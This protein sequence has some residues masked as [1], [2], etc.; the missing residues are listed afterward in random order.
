MAERIAHAAIFRT[1]NCVVFGRD[2]ADC[3]ERS[4]SGTAAK[5]AI[6]GFL[7]GKF[8]FVNR[9]EAASIA[10][11]AGQIDKI[12]P[13]E[14]LISEQ[15]LC[16]GKHIYD[17]ELGYILRRITMKVGTICKLKVN[18]LGNKVGTLGVV[19]WNYS[20]GFQVIFENGG[21]D[22]FSTLRRSAEI[23]EAD[24]FLEEV[25]FE[26]TLLDYQFINVMKVSLDYN[27]GLFD[28]AW[29]EGWK[30]YVAEGWT[31][32][33]ADVRSSVAAPEYEKC[34]VYADYTDGLKPPLLKFKRTDLR[35][36]DATVCMLSDAKDFVDFSHFEYAEFGKSIYP[37]W[38]QKD[39]TICP[40]YVVFRKK[41]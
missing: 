26:A 31:K 22:G 16:Y 6:Q 11:K 24:R 9:K 21:L 37:R 33:F 38:I 13:D 25:G 7:T 35:G 27:K 30:K 1:D 10:F 29:S 14:A 17:E 41:Q 19:F 5:G 2:H 3:I 36:W 23:S 20:D 39:K 12:E 18:C 28:I 32:K 8:R 34:A 4:P 40:L 15:L